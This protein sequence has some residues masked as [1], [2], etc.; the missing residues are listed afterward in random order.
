MTAESLQHRSHRWLGRVVEDTATGRKGILRAVAPDID[1]PR[2]V[3][4]LAPVG[5]GREWTTA[6][7]A[8]ANPAPL[9][10]DT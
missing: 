7:G 8:L 5:G 10:P 9:T 2:T 3:A 4:W 1:T 6:P